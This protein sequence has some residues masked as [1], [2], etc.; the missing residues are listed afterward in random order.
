M[1]RSKIH[2]LIIS[3]FLILVSCATNNVAKDLKPV[4]LEKT[5]YSAPYFSNPEI[6]Y[7]Y[8]TNITVYG[9]ELSG[10]FIAKKI[11]ATTHRVVF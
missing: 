11:N 2:F 6:D 7:V 10:I 4:V 5:V 8:K 1:Q 3:L 9:N